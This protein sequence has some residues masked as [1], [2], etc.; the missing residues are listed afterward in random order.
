MVQGLPAP[1]IRNHRDPQGRNSRIGMHSPGEVVEH[2]FRRQAGRMVATLVRI[3]GPGHLQMAED[4]VQE[5]LIRALE[6]WPHRG[7]PE[8]PSAWLIEVAKNRALD[9]LRRE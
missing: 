3:F 7:V 8:N 2:L 5:A 4:V 9:A 6:Q 1:V